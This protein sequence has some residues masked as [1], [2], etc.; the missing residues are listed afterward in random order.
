M[1]SGCTGELS[2]KIL[3][4]SDPAAIYGTERGG[5]MILS[6]EAIQRIKEIAMED[7]LKHRKGIDK[8]VLTLAEME[9][10]IENIL[11]ELGGPV[12][13]DL[14]QTEKSKISTQ[15][16]TVHTVAQS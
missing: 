16:K 2:V 3:V 15:K 10:L 1:L 5:T 8:K 12:F 11:T 13:V 7:I 9:D 14:L 6:K 4:L